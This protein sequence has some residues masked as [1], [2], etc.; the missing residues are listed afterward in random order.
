M[1]LKTKTEKETT[2]NYRDRTTNKDRYIDS[3]G[4]I[5]NDD[6]YDKDENG[7]DDKDIDNTDEDEKTQR[8]HKQNQ[9][10]KK[11]QS[12]KDKV[13]TD[14]TEKMTT[15]TTMMVLK[16]VK[17]SEKWRKRKR[18]DLIMFVY[19]LYCSYNRHDGDK[20]S[21]DHLQQSRLHKDHSFVIPV[22]HRTLQTRVEM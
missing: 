16:F 1:K 21:I 13:E 22:I 17:N 6:Q 20:S 18:Y 19:V 12:D 2:N 11:I 10:R 3:D 15:T 9:R 5:E 4:E 14:V 7:I 8:R